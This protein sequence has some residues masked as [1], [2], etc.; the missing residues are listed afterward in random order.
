MSSSS[1]RRLSREMVARALYQSEICGDSLAE[2]WKNLKEKDG[3]PSDARDYAT[4]LCGVLQERREEIDTLLLP[5][6]QNWTFDRLGVTDRG[7]MRMAAGE[8]LAMNQ[9]PARVVLDEAVAIAAKFG[10]GGSGS[11]VNGIL[12]QMARQL[13]PGEL[14]E[15]ELDRRGK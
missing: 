15:V 11:F 8:L 13:R 2:A 4:D 7:V 10:G 14:D 6:L 5:L 12:D 1:P 9:T 3:L